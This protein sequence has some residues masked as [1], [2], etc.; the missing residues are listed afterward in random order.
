[1]NKVT[2][3]QAQQTAGLEIERKKNVPRL[4]GYDFNPVRL[5]R[6]EPHAWTFVSGSPQLHKEGCAPGAFFVT[7]D[8]LDGHIW[9]DDEIEEYYT[10]LAAQR[11]QASA[12]VA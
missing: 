8:K 7:V 10:T 11:A 3:E 9:S 4:A 6:D 1:M 2:L 5:F 12:R